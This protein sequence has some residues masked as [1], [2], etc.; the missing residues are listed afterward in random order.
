MKNSERNLATLENF[1]LHITGS[2]EGDFDA[3][4]SQLWTANELYQSAKDYIEEDHVDGRNHL[5]EILNNLSDKIS[6]EHNEDN[7]LQLAYNALIRQSEIDDTVMADDV[8]TMWEPLE[9]T[10]TVRQLLNSI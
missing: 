2:T 4:T 8:V 3:N 6:L 9:N 7:E 1:I 5:D 10:L